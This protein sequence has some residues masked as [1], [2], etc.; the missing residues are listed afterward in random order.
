MF[1]QTSRIDN[2]YER[3][4]C[5]RG[6]IIKG[7]GG[8]YEIR[9]PDE[10]VVGGKPR[11]LFRNIG[12]VPTV[13]DQV[14]IEESGDSDFPYTITEIMDREN[15]LVRPPISNLHTLIITVACK[16]P[17][18]DYTLIDKLLIL[19]GNHSIH[20]II[21]IT[22]TDLAPKV[23]EQ[24]IKE[25]EQTRYC[26]ITT[27]KET[28]MSGIL[29]DLQKNMPGK[30][31]KII[32]FA[33]QSGVGK[34][35]LCNALLNRNTMKVGTVSKKLK[36]GR[37]TTRH[38][39]LLP[40]P[41]GYIADTPGFSSL[42]LQDVGIEEKDVVYG[43]PELQIMNEECRFQDCLHTG[44][45]GCAVDTSFIN[46]NRLSRYREFVAQLQRVKKY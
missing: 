29:S 35:T 34:S 39:E 19:C 26:M 3:R 36:R 31:E 17:A 11:G 20:P 41:G 25:Y 43:Y 4:D 1:F 45:A 27:G 24:L 16:M 10:E 9:L 15:I 37:H 18:P 6:I 42:R 28:D 33:G 12:L 22:K 44:E 23:A 7:V 2:F 46:E 40:Y 32:S 13:G 14:E 30:E 8:A 5:I 38:V 21:W